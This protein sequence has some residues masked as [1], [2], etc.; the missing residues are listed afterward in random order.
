MTTVTIR[1][2]SDNGTNEWTCSTGS[3]HYA[4]VD[5]AE[6]NDSDY[7]YNEDEVI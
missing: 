3:D 7:L 1:P 6:A 5:E 4:L 2:T